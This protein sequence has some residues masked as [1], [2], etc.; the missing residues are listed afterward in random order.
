[1][2]G[3]NRK[4]CVMYLRKVEGPRSITLPD[5]SIM[6]RADLPPEK[7][8][9]KDASSGLERRLLRSNLHKAGVDATEVIEESRKLQQ[10]CDDIE[11]FYGLW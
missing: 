3:S 2:V 4:G 10:D 9:A 6:T 1:M 5:G 8:P 11:G 7:D